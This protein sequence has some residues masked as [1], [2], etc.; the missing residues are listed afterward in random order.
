MFLR[1]WTDV[2][3][4]LDPHIHIYLKPIDDRQIELASIWVEKD[5]QGKGFG[6]VALSHITRLA[7]ETGVS[8][9]LYPESTAG[10]A[11]YER[12]ESYYNRFGFVSL[13]SDSMIYEPAEPLDDE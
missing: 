2:A 10:T 9:V 11:Y 3:P 12:L 7:D 8:I 5:S 6:T 13:G 4:T 1:R